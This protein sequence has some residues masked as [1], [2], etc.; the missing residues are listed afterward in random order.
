[1]IRFMGDVWGASPLIMPIIIPLLYRFLTPLYRFPSFII[2]R[3]TNSA[4]NL[5]TPHLLL[6]FALLFRQKSGRFEKILPI[7]NFKFTHI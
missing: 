4:Q 6:I 7:N 2:P 5:Q 3:K 1:M